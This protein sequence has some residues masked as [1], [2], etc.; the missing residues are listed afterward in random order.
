MAHGDDLLQS[1]RALD[2]FGHARW[3]EAGS[4]VA[5]AARWLND[6]RGADRHLLVPGDLLSPCFAD[7]GPRSVGESS[8]GEWWLVTPPAATACA[9]RGNPAHVFHYQLSSVKP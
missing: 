4:E 8:G 7:S 9:A 3:R 1:H 2:N 6:P 5:D